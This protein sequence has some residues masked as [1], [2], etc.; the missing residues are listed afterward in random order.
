MKT[1]YNKTQKGIIA[2]ILLIILAFMSYSY[3]YQTGSKPLPFI[4]Y[5]VLMIVFIAIILLFYKLTITI[6]NEKITA[7][8]GI[9]IFKKS[10]NLIDIHSI[11]SYK[12]PWYA[13]IG[14]RLTPKG[15]LW[16]VK[17][18]KAILIQNKSKTQ[19]FLVGSN[20]VNKIISVLEKN[21][22]LVEINSDNT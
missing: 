6:D 13:G 10:M 12:I 21:T 20:E 16:N 4:P 18:G 5:I 14:V 3:F 7:I 19:T 22:N 8:F 2:I 11:E 15:W 9:G 17:M 1:I